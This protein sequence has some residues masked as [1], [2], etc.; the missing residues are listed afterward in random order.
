MIALAARDLAVG[1]D[2]RPVVEGIGL[3]LAPGDTLAVVGT[4]GSGK[5]TFVRTAAGLLPPVHG[6]VTALGGPPG[7]APARVAY[8]AQSHP[9]GFV[10]PLRA[11]DVVAMGR[12]ASLGLLRRAGADDRRRVADAM[13]RMGI[14]HLADAPLGG[15]SG[16]QRQRVHIARILAWGAD[17]LILDEPTSGLDVAGRELLLT[18][19][20]EERRRGAAVVLCTHDIS[21]AL[22]ADLVLLLAGRVV[23]CGPPA[24][25]LT[26]E[27]LLETFGLVISG[28]PGEEG[29]VMD[30]SHRHDHEAVP[31]EA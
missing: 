6:G 20:A 8:L 25:V 22:V 3:G 17:L 13:A 5:T 2:G 28:L 14:A 1:Y 7:A 19:L 30:P 15:L 21:D 16:G 23:A 24:E 27:S 26:R 12:F 31:P 10:L 18:A 9:A 11:R 29:L 4:N